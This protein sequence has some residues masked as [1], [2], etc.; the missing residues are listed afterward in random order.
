MSN[1]LPVMLNLAGRRCVVV[2]G[3][4][5]AA[6]KI[7]ALLEADASITLISPEIA[8]S[9]KNLLQHIHWEQRPYKAGDLEAYRP[10]LVYATTNDPDV[11]RQIAQ[12]ANALGA[13]V[14]V[15]D[16]LNESSFSNMMT[17]RRPPL[18]IALHTGGTSP[19]LARHLSGV[20][21]AAVG[22]EYAILARWLGDLR[23]LSRDQ[24]DTQVQRQQLYEAVLASDI[25][26]LLQQHQVEQA[27][28]QFDELAQA[29]GVNA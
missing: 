3:G 11:N 17:L 26:N 20:L 5:V 8:D 10:T 1:G 24:V 22:E 23:T 19:A 28:Q 14:N 13:L 16:E 25:L 18:T 4:T 2:G 21:D 29:W 9:I 7:T 6:R 27:R 12:E 15:A